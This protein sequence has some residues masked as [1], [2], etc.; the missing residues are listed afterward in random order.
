MSKRVICDPITIA[1]SAPTGDGGA[2]AVVCNERFLRENHLEVRQRI[3]WVIWERGEEREE[4][5]IYY[6]SW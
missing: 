5:E 4:G 1:M 3:P 2:A 6:C